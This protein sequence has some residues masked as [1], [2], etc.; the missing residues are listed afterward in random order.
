MPYT[1]FVTEEWAAAEV[2][3]L[4]ELR[5]DAIECRCAALLDLGRTAQAVPEL[6]A[7][8]REHPLREELRR[9][10][11]LG[12]YRAGRQA[13]ALAAVRRARAHLAAELGVDPGPRL[14]ELESMLLTQDETLLAPAPRLRP[15][16]DAAQPLTGRAE[17]LG[18]LLGAAT[19]ATDRPAC[20]LISGEAGGQNLA[21][22]AARGVAR[23][24]GMADRLGAV[25]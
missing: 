23:R 11:A 13:D 17:P 3:R 16:P 19:T 15:S 4:E 14:R 5:L 9:L 18:V 24:T 10:L 1:E 20:A 8:V 12:L 22:H 21:R 2:S 6:D 25:E 7:S